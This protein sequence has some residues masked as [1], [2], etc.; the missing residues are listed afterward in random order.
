MAIE[1]VEHCLQIIPAVKGAPQK[2]LWEKNR[3]GRIGMAR[4]AFQDYFQRF[5]D[6]FEERGY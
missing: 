4:L 2:Y 3:T 1:M 6:L 5:E